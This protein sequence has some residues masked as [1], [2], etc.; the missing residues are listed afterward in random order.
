M[1]ESKDLKFSEVAWWRRMGAEGIG[2]A[3]V[4]DGVGTGL[5]GVLETW[6]R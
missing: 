2:C 3:N 4:G 5:V 1:C 6:L